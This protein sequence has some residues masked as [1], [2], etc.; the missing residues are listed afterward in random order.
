MVRQSRRE[1]ERT[2]E[3]LHGSE[4]TPDP[5]EVDLSDEDAEDIRTLFRWRR[6][7]ASETGEHLDD[8]R[9]LANILTRARE[10]VPAGEVAVE[11]LYEAASNAGLE[12]GDG[13]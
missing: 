3:S 9:V 12:L 13:Q 7:V 11:T 6:E 2:V 4:Q 5:S 8:R 1:L 10:A